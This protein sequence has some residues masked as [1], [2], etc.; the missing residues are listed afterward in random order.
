MQGQCDLSGRGAW[1]IESD[2]SMLLLLPAKLDLIPPF[3][4]ST[5][6][7]LLSYSLQG[8]KLRARDW[9]S[10]SQQSDVDNHTFDYSS[11]PNWNAS[12]TDLKRFICSQLVQKID[13]NT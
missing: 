11:I 9:I 10:S 4:L 5:E 2:D 8:T 1:T 13:L 6:L 3:S 7:K 12:D